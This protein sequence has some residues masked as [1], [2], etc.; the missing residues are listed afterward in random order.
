MS[1]RVW[2][3]NSKGESVQV[4]GNNSCPASFAEALIEQG[5]DIDICDEWVLHDF[6]VKDVQALVD[7]IESDMNKSHYLFSDFADLHRSLGEYLVA[8]MTYYGA[9]RMLVFEKK[10]FES[11]NF[12]EHLRRAG[13]VEVSMDFKK[14][15]LV[16][17][18]T[19]R[20]SMG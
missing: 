6:E 11:Y 17:G 15:R 9:V 10:L 1:H 19:V 4:F 5:A 2:L 20:I 7:A 18:R 13:D 3:E 8:G 16:E 12:V 14:V